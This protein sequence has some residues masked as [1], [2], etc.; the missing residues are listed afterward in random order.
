MLLNQKTCMEH[1]FSALR[2]VQ[3]LPVLSI[4]YPQR[5]STA[6]NIER[7]FSSVFGHRLHEIITINS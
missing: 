6:L 5:K 1:A 2:L 7:G 3:M 4:H